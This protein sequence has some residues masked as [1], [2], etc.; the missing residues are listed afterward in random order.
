[1]KANRIKVLFKENH[2]IFPIGAY[3]KKEIINALLMPLLKYE[4]ISTNKE[5]LLSSLLERER[6]GS[7][8]LQNGLAIP[9]S[10]SHLISK[11]YLSLGVNVEGISFDAIDEKVTKIIV[12]AL[13]PIS[14]S[15]LHLKLI[16]KICRFLYD[17]ELRKKIYI[18]SN[19]KEIWQ[20]T[21]KIKN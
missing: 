1:M 20:I 17:E 2:I 15:E 16:S 7:T 5:V 3:S 12:L 8:G 9:H 19:K 21:K 10:K 11:A 4:E 14:S 6:K 13:L 18:C